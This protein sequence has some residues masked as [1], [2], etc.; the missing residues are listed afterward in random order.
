MDLYRVAVVRELF[1]QYWLF[2]LLHYNGNRAY[3]HW[4]NVVLVHFTVHLA[5]RSCYTL[6][7]C[8]IINDSHVVFK[9]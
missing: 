9:Y 1:V 5:L 6:R 4:A 3:A 7:P 2:P 8:F